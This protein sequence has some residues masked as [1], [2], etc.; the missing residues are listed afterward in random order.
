MLRDNVVP[1]NTFKVSS[2]SFDRFSC[3]FL[4]SI[5]KIFAVFTVHISVKN[6]GILSTSHTE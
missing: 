4:S 6:V 5:Q 2:P 1:Q 3:K